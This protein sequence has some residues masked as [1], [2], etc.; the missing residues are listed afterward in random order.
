LDEPWCRAFAVRLRRVEALEDLL[1]PTFVAV[2]CTVFDK[3]AD[4]NWLVSLHQDLSIPV[5]RR[6]DDR[7]CSGWS[8]KEG[9][10]YVQPPVS[11]LDQLVAVRIHLDDCGAENGP[12]RVVAGSHGLGRLDKAR[13]EDVRVQR[14]EKSIPVGRGGALVMKPLILHASSKSSAPEPRRVL[15]FVFGPPALPCGLERCW[16]I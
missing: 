1:S 9:E 3:S 15:H 6:V 12:L 13:S 11:V 16:A 5:K 2:Q 8:A 14:G 10:I 4:K 7:E